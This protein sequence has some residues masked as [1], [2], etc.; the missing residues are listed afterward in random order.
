VSVKPLALI[1]KILGRSPQVTSP[2]D[3][4]PSCF[5]DVPTFDEWFPKL[6]A[7]FLLGKEAQEDFHCSTALREGT[8][9]F[10]RVFVDFDEKRRLHVILCWIDEACRKAKARREKEAKGE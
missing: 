8:D 9:E 5:A 10:G 1:R 7:N 3:I 2:P 6:A 4:D